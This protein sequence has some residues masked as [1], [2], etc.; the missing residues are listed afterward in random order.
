MKNHYLAGGGIFSTP[1]Q[2][3]IR[4]TYHHIQASS[5]AV[6]CHLKSNTAGTLYWNLSRKLRQLYNFIAIKPSPKSWKKEIWM[7][8]SR[9]KIG[10]QN[11]EEDKSISFVVR[12]LI[13][14]FQRMFHFLIGKTVCLNCDD[15]FS[16]KICYKSFATRHSLWNRNNGVDF[17]FH[18]QIYPMPITGLLHWNQDNLILVKLGLLSNLA[19]WYTI[20]KAQGDE[21]L[22]IVRVLGPRQSTAIIF[23]WFLGDR[24]SNSYN[25][26]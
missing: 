13:Y 5:D 2:T 8:I 3:T 22:T 21:S 15:T 9:E 23:L 18:F 20:C 6:F 7:A 11:K 25:V 12:N 26:K 16:N 4:F 14:G 1:M 19:F 17:L 10:K 24:M